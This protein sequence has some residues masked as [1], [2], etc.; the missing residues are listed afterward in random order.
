MSSTDEAEDEGE[1]CDFADTNDNIKNCVC[2]FCSHASLTAENTFFHIKE[3]HKLDFINLI[4]ANH[5]DFYKYV[6]LVNYIRS[7]KTPVDSVHQL[8]FDL[9]YADDKW[10]QPVIED[11][12]LLQYDVDEILSKTRS[13]TDFNLNSLNELDLKKKLDITE[14][15]ACLAEEFLLRTI[16]DLNKCRKEI[17]LMLLEN[18][19]QPCKTVT[20]NDSN[21]YFGSYAH[22]GI[23][24]EML[25][26]KVRTE[27]YKDFIYNNPKIFSG[28]K[29]LD[30]G[31]G[32]SILSMFSAKAGARQVVGVDYSEVA[33]QAMD[34]VREN[35]MENSIM[36]VKGKAED[37]NLDEK[38]DVIVSE[39]MGYFLLFESML[40]TVLYCRDH[41]LKE[42]GCVYP[43]KC[44][45]QLL[46]MHDADLYKN[47]IVYWDDVYGFKMS[48]MKKNVFE[49]P[50]I[51]V[52]RS[53]FIVSKSYELIN[54]DLMKVNTAQLEFD[55]CF[56]LEFISDGIMSALVGYF[57]VEF[58]NQSETPIQMST[59]PFDFPTHW[60]QTVF[61]L[62]EPFFI[63]S[64]DTLNG[65][66]ICKRNKKDF[67]ALDIAIFFY[68][69]NLKD[70]IFKQYYV[71][72]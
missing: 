14:E 55:Q 25:K 62:K 18:P 8:S 66:L 68:D 58:N 48:S 49:E 54:F 60:K 61:F 24:E 21:G 12:L 64:G 40:D 44:N 52:V 37:L 20:E 27:A 1:W 4:K 57:N 13:F 33:Y 56:I 70:I 63:K 6:K 31:C 50:L 15:R 51:E 39:W 22:F 2:L 38:F 47:K 42:G 65:R 32:T 53:D 10:F 17:N 45:I 69:K 16:D 9:I 35:H 26:D 5:I 23:H 19:S 28:A 72:S 30:I 7:N 67:R 46:G 34:I 3:I 43:N 36:I 71:M 11:D 41:Y 59:S 29:V